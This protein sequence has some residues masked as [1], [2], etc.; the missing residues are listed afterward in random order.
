MSIEL[1]K[2]DCNCNDCKF[3]VRD[4]EKYNREVKSVGGYKNQVFGNC[5]KF[6]KPVNVIPAIC[7]IETQ[8]CFVHRKD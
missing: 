5:D 6:N 4:I 8:N 3:F 1:Q 2:L 7:L